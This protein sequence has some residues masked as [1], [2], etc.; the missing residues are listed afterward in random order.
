MA[1]WLGV[2]VALVEDLGL[3]PRFHKAAHHVSPLLGGV[4]GGPLEGLHAGK[5]PTYRNK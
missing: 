2:L 3:T 1:Q 4:L 5:M